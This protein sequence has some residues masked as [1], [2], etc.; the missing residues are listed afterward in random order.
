MQKGLLLILNGKRFEN[1]HSFFHC[2]TKKIFYDS[3]I[4]NKITINKIF[5]IIDFYIFQ[6]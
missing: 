4:Y 1:L 6:N 3:R 5:F 2:S